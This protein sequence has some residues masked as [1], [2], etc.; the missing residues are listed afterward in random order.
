[1]F[2]SV[3]LFV[4]IGLCV[5]EVIGSEIGGTIFVREVG[6]GLSLVDITS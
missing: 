1:M 6:I 5:I 2:N 4:C 3:G